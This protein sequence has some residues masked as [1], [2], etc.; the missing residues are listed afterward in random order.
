VFTSSFTSELGLIHPSVDLLLQFIETSPQ[1]T[2]ERR[3]GRQHET[4]TGP[5]NPGVGPC[6][7]DR[8]A[9]SKVSEVVAVCLGDAFDQAV[10]AEASQLIGHAT[11]SE[12]VLWLPAQGCQI[13]SQVS[14]GESSR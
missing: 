7:K 11:L 9:E 12:L 1:R 13:P 5:Q 2:W 3:R 10:Q 8:D 14:V 6:A 4:E